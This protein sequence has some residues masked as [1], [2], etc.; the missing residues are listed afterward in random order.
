MSLSISLVLLPTQLRITA[1]TRLGIPSSLHS[2]LQQQFPS[3]QI[4][5]V[6]LSQ[7]ET[8]QN[9]ARFYSAVTKIARAIMVVEMGSHHKNSSCSITQLFSQKCINL[10]QDSFTSACKCCPLYVL[11][12]IRVE[13]CG[14]ILTETSEF[15]PFLPEECNSYHF[16]YSGQ[17]FNYILY[18]FPL[19][20]SGR[21]VSVTSS[22]SVSSAQEAGFATS[23]NGSCKTDVGA[24]CFPSDN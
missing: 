13:V 21:N 19:T 23:F 3:P 12:R 5:I 20:A 10:T 15:V 6:H 18:D 7:T 8:G 11:V 24:K 9:W 16:T 2:D 22:A 4:K 17:I 14:L 1:A